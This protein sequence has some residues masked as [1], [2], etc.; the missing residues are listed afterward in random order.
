[1]IEFRRQGSPVPV[2]D[3]PDQKEVFFLPSHQQDP[4]WPGLCRG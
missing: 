3:F 4:Q 2:E 1:M